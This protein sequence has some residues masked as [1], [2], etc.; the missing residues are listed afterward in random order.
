VLGAGASL[1]HLDPAWFSGKI[2]VAVN[3]VAST[4]GIR[5][6][7]V[8]L[9]EF[10]ESL[11]I[12]ASDP[13]DVPIV[14]SRFPYGDP[15]RGFPP[16]DETPYLALDNLYVFDHLPNRSGDFDAARDWPADDGSLVVSMSTITSAMH[17]A[18]L[19]GAST[20]FMVGHDCG[21]LGEAAYM[22]GYGKAEAAMGYPVQQVEWLIALERQSRAVKAQLVERY[23]V[24][25]WSV[26]P[27]LSPRLD[28]IPYNGGPGA[29]I[30]LDTVPA[31]T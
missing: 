30:N 24:R 21:Q 20:I 5:P 18:A 19:L 8:V 4:W 27:F 25:V 15:H 29:Q 3:E 7:Y 13:P 1:D 17:F 16:I 31:I 23:G 14:C 22:K 26:S 11:L 12:A 9:K 2:T 28:G 6:S 10:A